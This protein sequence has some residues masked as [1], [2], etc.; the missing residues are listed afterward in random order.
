[1]TP[2]TIG[3]DR[4]LTRAAD[5]TDYPACLS[6]AR[7]QQRLGQEAYDR[8]APAAPH[9]PPAVF[10]FN[11]GAAAFRAPGRDPIYRSH[12]DP[13]PREADALGAVYALSVLDRLDAPVRFLR[14]YARH[15][16]PGGLLVCTFALW[17][18]TGEDCALGH[19]LR[20]RIYDQHTWKRLVTDAKS[21]GFAPLGGVD[22]RYHGDLLGDHTLASLVVI[23]ETR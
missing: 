14:A 11:W 18:A 8:W 19:E 22:F 10:C 7:W 20:R 23:R 15:L 12:G 2:V 21:L 6:V 17:N 5:L 4:P 13:L 1:M 16:V 3:L 9:A